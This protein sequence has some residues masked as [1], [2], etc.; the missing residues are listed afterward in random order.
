LN[1]VD[2]YFEENM[3]KVLNFEEDNWEHRNNFENQSMS[4][5]NI[6]AAWLHTGIVYQVLSVFITKENTI[7]HRIYSEDGE[8]IYVL[9]L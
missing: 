9:I 6:I 1:S 7:L 8:D 3:G 5:R 2:D 4:L